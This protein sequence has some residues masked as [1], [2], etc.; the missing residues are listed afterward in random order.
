MY[1][2]T[3]IS[4]DSKA[5]LQM[6]NRARP[7]PQA[8]HNLP[9]PLPLSDGL[10][11]SG[12]VERVSGPGEEGMVVQASDDV[13]AQRVM[14][15]RW[16]LGAEQG[17]QERVSALGTAKE[18]LHLVDSMSSSQQQVNRHHRLGLAYRSGKASGKALQERQLLAQVEK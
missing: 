8:L 12:W 18:H 4:M 15:G 7:R 11:S 6:V 17:R 13:L 16:V 5:F 10:D 14:E 2:S 9:R 3:Q 1:S